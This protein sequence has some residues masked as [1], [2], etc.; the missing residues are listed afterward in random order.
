MSIAHKL[1]IKDRMLQ[2]ADFFTHKDTSGIASLLDEN[3]QLFDPALKWVRGKQAVLNVLAKQFRETNHIR[4]EAIHAY[5][6]GTMGILE[7]KI[8][9]DELILEGVDFMLWNNQKM[10]ELRCYYNP[11]HLTQD[12][13]L[14]PFS[15]QSKAIKINA[16]YEHYKGKR[17]RVLS[18][19]R[20]SETL[21]ES[22]V[23]QAL[24]GSQDVWV[25]PLKMFTETVSINGQEKPRFSYL[26]D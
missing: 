4:Y 22:V 5:E 12:P 21:E 16:I 1:T 8:T 23:Y 15:Q 14:K 19:G 11:P 24:Y 13:L 26:E 2:F 18:I 3:F 25:R 20:N 7:F 10:T 17:Y 6:E 9:L